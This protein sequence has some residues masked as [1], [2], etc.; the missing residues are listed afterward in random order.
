[1]QTKLT[2]RLEEHLIEKAKEYAEKAGKSV[3]QL[4]AEYFRLLTC[5]KTGT[6]S[7]SATVTRSLRGLLRECELDEKDYRKYLEEKHR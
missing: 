4:V 2:L 1:M 7:S 6:P 5:E 3:S